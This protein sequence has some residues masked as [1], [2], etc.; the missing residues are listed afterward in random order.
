MTAGC[1]WCGR[2]KKNRKLSRLRPPH[3]PSQSSFVR[4]VRQ[5]TE[6]TLKRVM[7]NAPNP[8]TT[9]PLAATVEAEA[10]EAT[11]VV[12][13]I[14]VAIEKTHHAKTTHAVATGRT[15]PTATMTI[16]PRTQRLIPHLADRAGAGVR[17]K[18]R[19]I[20]VPETTN[21]RVEVDAVVDRGTED[22]IRNRPS[23]NLLPRRM[24]LRVQAK[25]T[26]PETMPNPAPRIKS[27]N[28][29][30]LRT[31]ESDQGL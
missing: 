28:G 26:N 3:R 15:L 1:D 8:R 14:A 5:R 7:P 17:Q 30:E 13:V 4:H 12:A 21:A 10:V 24:G 2:A 27:D 25:T 9:A 11:G 29:V 16:A 31:V 23:L 20:A 22:G 18:A 6:S 19:K